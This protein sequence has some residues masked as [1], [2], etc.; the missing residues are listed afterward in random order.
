MRLISLCDIR[1]SNSRTA[2]SSR[3]VGSGRFHDSKEAVGFSMTSNSS[4]I[5]R[6]VA[7]RLLAIMLVTLYVKSQPFY[8]FITPFCSV[9][10]ISDAASE[11][12]G[13]HK[14]PE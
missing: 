12:D 3:L 7:L 9:L 13:E 4:K 10:W 2:L 5:V 14:A 6:D 8:A 1:I 11:D